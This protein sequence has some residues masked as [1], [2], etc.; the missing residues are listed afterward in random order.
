MPCSPFAT[1][2]TLARFASRFSNRSCASRIGAPV[3]KNRMADTMFEH[4]LD[5]CRPVPLAQYLKGLG[6]LRLVAEQ[7]DPEARGAWRHD[8]FELHT[9]LDRQALESFFLQ[10]YHPTPILAPWNG[11][12]G[13]YPGDN[14]EAIA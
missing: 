13:F 7:A 12:S 10:S 5:G 2:R 14:K 11:G 6:I 4:T 1:R 8:R 9:R 3:K